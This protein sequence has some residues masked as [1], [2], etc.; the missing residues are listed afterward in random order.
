MTA[1]RAQ[2]AEVYGTETVPERPRSYARAVANAQEAHEAIRPAGTGSGHPTTCASSRDEWA[3][4][5]LIWKR[6]IASQMGMRPA[7]R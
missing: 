1:A 3:L 5:E 2:A 6:T 7:R 4:Y